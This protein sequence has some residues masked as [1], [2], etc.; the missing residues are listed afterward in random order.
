[1]PDE[2]S[3]AVTVSR[4]LDAADREA[5]EDDC[6]R[7]LPSEVTFKSPDRDPEWEGKA[8]GGGPPQILFDL[9]A[10]AGKGILDGTA[11]L[12]VATGVH[13]VVRLVLGRD[14]SS[15]PQPPSIEVRINQLNV[16]YLFPYDVA[17]IE[18]AA[19]AL[20]DHLASLIRSDDMTGLWWQEGNW[21]PAHD[22]D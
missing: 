2:T 6:R 20:P 7:L 18:A 5:L 19:G 4:F 22:D 8:V 17:E 15:P 9:A 12:L 10:E 3:T 13:R 16:T 21:V 11:F 1:M 14:K